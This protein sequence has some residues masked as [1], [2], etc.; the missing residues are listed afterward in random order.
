LPGE[1]DPTD[2]QAVT[3]VFA[4][5]HRPGEDHATDPPAGYADWARRVPDLDPPWPG[6]LFSWTI[7]G[8]GLRPRHLGFVPWPDTP[9]PDTLE[10]WRYR[11]VVDRAAHLGQHPPPDVCL[12]NWVQNDYFL[13]PTL[14]V[15]ADHAAAAFAAA[16]HQ[17]ACLLHWLRTDAPR[18]DDRSTGYPGLKLHPD[19]MGTPDGFAAACYIREPR[20][21]EARVMVSEAHLGAEHRRQAGHPDAT[22]LA[23]PAA[24]PFP[25]AIAI[26]H[27]PI[28]LHPSTSGRNQLYVEACPFVLPLRCLLPVRV[29]NL[30][31][32]GKAIGV[33]H[34]ANGA[35]RLH[36]VEWAIGEAAGTAAAICRHA[37]VPPGAIVEDAG[38]LGT[39]QQ[40]LADAG[41][42]LSW[43]W[44]GRSR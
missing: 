44:G 36:P 21:L 23:T 40:A 7:C 28:D 15:S 11:R 17:S 8:E 29:S 43:P 32:A 13:K 12:V 6:P 26:G 34:I 39:L 42:P 27:Y 20:R 4:I 33:T 30:L 22:P 2:Q 18:H 41:A 35:T 38:R 10:L 9:P 24:E 16:R 31:A 1:P 19:A 5:E 37:R 25:D 3:W 14:G